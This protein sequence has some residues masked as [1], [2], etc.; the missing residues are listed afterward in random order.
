MAWERGADPCHI[1][2]FTFHARPALAFSLSWKVLKSIPEAAKQ[3][4]A[5]AIPLP[6]RSALL[7]ALGSKEGP[8]FVSECLVRRLG[9]SETPPHTGTLR[10]QDPCRT[11]QLLSPSGNN[12][13]K[14]LWKAFKACPK[15][16][17]LPSWIVEIVWKLQ[18]PKTPAI[19]TGHR[20]FRIF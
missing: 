17:Y 5:P 3:E 6:G 20:H 12:P 10:G 11:S 18:Q 19:S 8:D 1:D 15:R 2:S 16:N 14:S 9:T 7:T 13:S 4:A